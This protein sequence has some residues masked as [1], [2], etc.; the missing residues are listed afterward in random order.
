MIFF[1]PFSPKISY[2]HPF[3][4]NKWWCPFQPL[5]IPKGHYS[6]YPTKEWLLWVTTGYIRFW[7][8]KFCLFFL[9]LLSLLTGSQWVVKWWSLY[10]SYS[11]SPLPKFPAMSPMSPTMFP[12]CPLLCS[13]YVP[14]YVP[15]LCPQPMLPL[16]HLLCP[17]FPLLCLHSLLFTHCICPSLS[18]WLVKASHLLAN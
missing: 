14:F 16:C 6:Y 17:S 10:L 13:L 5:K 2:Y 3:K 1:G 9:L 7:K 12:L 4:G 8:I 11:Y 18:F 15:I